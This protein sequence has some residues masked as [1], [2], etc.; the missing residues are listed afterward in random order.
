[1]LQGQGAYGGLGAYGRLGL[2]QLGDYSGPGAY[3][4]RGIMA[5]WGLTAVNEVLLSIALASGGKENYSSK[6]NYGKG[7]NRPS[8]VSKQ[9]ERLMGGKLQPFN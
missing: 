4:S 2:R 3:S 6:G 9:C 8:V 1:M 5:G 7:T